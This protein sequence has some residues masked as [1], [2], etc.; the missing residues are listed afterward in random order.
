MNDEVSGSCESH[1]VNTIEDAMLPMQDQVQVVHTVNTTEN[2]LLPMPDHVQAADTL[3]TTDNALL[4]MQ[5]QVQAVDTLNTTENALLPMQ[6]QVQAVYLAVDQAGQV[7][8]ILGQPYIATVNQPNIQLKDNQVEVAPSTENLIHSLIP[9]VTALQSLTP[10]QTMLHSD[11]DNPDTSS[12][13]LESIDIQHDAA[14]TMMAIGSNEKTPENPVLLVE[15]SLQ[16]GQILTSGVHTSEVNYVSTDQP[17]GSISVQAGPGCSQQTVTLVDKPDNLVA[18]LRMLQNGAAL[19]TDVSQDGTV[20]VQQAGLDDAKV[21]DTQQA[22]S[23]MAELQDNI[24]H[25]QSFAAEIEPSEH[26]PM[27]PPQLMA[28]SSVKEESSAVSFHPAYLENIPVATSKSPSHIQ[29][30]DSKS[31]EITVDEGGVPEFVADDNSTEKDMAMKLHNLE[32]EDKNSVL[33]REIS[34]KV[35]RFNKTD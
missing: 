33:C 17:C 4:P 12:A 30:L 9:G 8:Q 25:M 5:D 23:L 21:T 10:D 14:L 3:N 31:A 34:C 26:S 20:T 24:S 16:E 32:N 2:A 29:E 28:D 15:N 11:T 35:C 6:D 27:P 18:L 22:A 1:T 19:Q 13:N 7:V